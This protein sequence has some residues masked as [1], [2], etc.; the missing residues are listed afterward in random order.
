[1]QRT[2]MRTASLLACTIFLSVLLV[3]PSHSQTGNY[4][5]WGS[6]TLTTGSIRTGFDFATDALR[7]E[8]FANIRR[9]ASEV[10]GSKGGTY[11]AITCVGTAPRVTA[12]VMVTGGNNA[13]T[14]QIRNQVVQK[15]KGIIRFD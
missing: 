10:T 6:T 11:V 3:F 8:G 12:I 7:G 13:A 14:A 5:Y 15:I 2:I 1:M 4:L 9:S